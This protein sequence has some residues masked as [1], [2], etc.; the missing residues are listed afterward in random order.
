MKN[1]GTNHESLVETSAVLDAYFIEN[2]A[3]LLDIAAFMDRVGRS[4]RSLSSITDHRWHAIVAGLTLLLDG[5]P[6]RAKRALESWSDPTATPI[7]KATVKG[8]TGAWDGAR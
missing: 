2:R 5:Q 7:A 3:K 8:A 4:T 6:D 1:S